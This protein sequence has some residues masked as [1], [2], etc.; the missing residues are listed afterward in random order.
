MYI[1]TWVMQ[2]WYRVAKR[3][4]MPYLC[5]SLSAKEP[6]NYWLFWGNRPANYGILRIFATSY[7][8]WLAPCHTHEWVTSHICIELCVENRM[9]ESN[10][11]VMIWYAPL[12]VC[13]FKMIVM[14]WYANQNDLANKGAYQMIIKVHTKWFG[15]LANKGAYQMIIKV[16]TK[17]FGAYQ[18]NMIWQI[19]VHTKWHK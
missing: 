1:M 15:D 11:E 2:E 9:E 10:F 3:H 5:R 14:I 16:H 19:K 12:F 17:W 8:T 18:I 6:Y 13:D 4:R 7:H